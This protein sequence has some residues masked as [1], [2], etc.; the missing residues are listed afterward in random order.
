MK[1]RR[2]TAATAMINSILLPQKSLFWLGCF[3]SA[4]RCSFSQPLF[5]DP[6]A[7]RTPPE[8]R[9]GV[10]GHAFDHLGNIGD[11]AEAAAASG[12]NIIY[13]T[14]LGA[15]GYGGLPSPSNISEQKE[16]TLAYLRDA[17]R[18][19]IRLAIGY[20]CAT[21]IVKLDTFDRNWAPEFRA[22]FST[23]PSAWR[24]QDQNGNPLPSWYG[25]DY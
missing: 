4:V 12:A 10:A 11:Q 15:A 25:S 23:P 24:Q 16:R 9:L 1:G 5:A 17:R 2:K 22:R 13:I 14:G 18:K 6:H 19:G 21:S 20:I 7:F 8:L 3:L